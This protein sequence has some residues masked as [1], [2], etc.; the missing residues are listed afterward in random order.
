MKLNTLNTKKQHVL[1]WMV[2][3]TFGLHTAVY[4]QNYPNTNTKTNQYQNTSFH[5]VVEIPEMPKLPKTAKNIIL[6][7]G[8]GMG[9]AQVYA[10][11]TANKGQ[12]N[13]M[14]FPYS[15][16]S[17]TTSASN[18]IT[19]SAAGGTAL[20][21]GKKTYNG[22]IGVDTA[23]TPIKTIL[24]IAEEMGKGTGLVSSSSI[25][26]AT[27]ASFIAHQPERGMQE[28]IAA[29]FLKT[30]IDVFI[31]GGKKYFDQR[32]DSVN[33]LKELEQQGYTVVDN[34]PAIEACKADKIA[35][36]IGT[37]HGDKMPER[38]NALTISTQ[39]ALEVL[40]N[41]MN[42]FFLMV[43]GSQIDWGGH[44]NNVEYITRE[45]LDFD[46]A[47]G[48]ALEFAL[49]D[50]NTLVIVT[51]DHETGGLAISDGNMETGFI[52]GSFTTNKHTG[53]MV[54]VFA[55]GP[56]AEKFSGMYDN[57]EIF[58]LMLNHWVKPKNNGKSNK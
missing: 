53:V 35:G 40:S 19:D 44:A 46:K 2:L 36:F 3:L 31:G 17:I 11:L 22:A 5:S 32:T 48:A 6:L 47:I 18:Y 27:P 23:G 12:L 30:D 21:T 58:H 37:E 51:A 38:G 24:E 4:S 52:R 26:H 9:S 49:K 8:D 34:L 57:T 28:E 25:T 16:Y 15:G 13:L 10:G 54:P 29:D 41:K 55:F 1:R 7:I 39:K 42:G 20:S 14:Q 33:L 56:G 45:M 50:K 43:E